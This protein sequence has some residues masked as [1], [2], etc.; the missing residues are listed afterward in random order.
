MNPPAMFT[1]LT[2]LILTIIA[3]Y[4]VPGRSSLWKM[5]FQQGR[6]T[7]STSY[8]LSFSDAYTVACAQA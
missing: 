3:L 2:V 1:D 4:R 6:L 5:I 8:L 7:P